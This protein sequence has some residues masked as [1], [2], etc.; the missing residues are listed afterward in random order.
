MP[1]FRHSLADNKSVRNKRGIAS[2]EIV[3]GPA[4]KD[5]NLTV[6]AFPTKHA[7]ESYGYRF[8]TPDRSVVISGDTAPSQ[9]S[10]VA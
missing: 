9:A 4:Y 3:A 1:E 8:D 5:A 2:D 7:M 10:I 6:T